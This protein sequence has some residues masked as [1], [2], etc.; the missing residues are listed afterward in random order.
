M[1][2]NNKLA[3][4]NPTDLSLVENNSLNPKQ[5]AFI[6]KRTP[7]QFVKQRPAKGGG[8]WDYV[9]GGY[10]KKIL[11]LAF[12]FDWDFEIIDEKILIEAKEVVVKGKLTIRTN[13]KTITKMQYGN[14]DIIF[15]TEPDFNDDGT[16]KMVQKYGKTVQATK[17][18]NIPLSVG[19]DMKSAATDCLKKCASEIGIA[20][21]IYNSDEFKEVFVDTEPKENLFENLEFLFNEKIKLIPE[22]DLQNIVDVIE[23]KRESQYKNAI[24][25]LKKL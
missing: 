24:D 9:S 15:R 23:N 2:D 20:A 22:S 6:L 5:L 12:G 8:T 11:N 3:L 7:K 4:V 14:K 25:Y 16:P 10:V 19:N 21:D 18:S 1:E 13:G 17:P